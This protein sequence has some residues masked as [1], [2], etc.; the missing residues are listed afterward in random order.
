MLS[1]KNLTASIHGTP[2][3]MG[4]DLLVEALAIV[5]QSV[6][7]AV[8]LL[9]GDDASNPAIIETVTKAK[10]RAQ[11]LGVTFHVIFTGVVDDQAP[12]YR[13]ADVYATASLHEGFGV[14]L[15][16]AVRFLIES[17]QNSKDKTS[18]IFSP[19]FLQASTTAAWWLRRRTPWGARGR[20]PCR[21]R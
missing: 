10:A 19:H 12:C 2:V 1:I 9:V 11:E 6:L 4:I 14:P 3:L 5:R 18:T 15:I 7:N 21:S 20:R 8:L 17:I 13:L 16:E